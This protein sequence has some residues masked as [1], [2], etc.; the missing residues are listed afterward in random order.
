VE[1][2]PVRADDPDVV[3]L[4]D[5]LTAE[6]AGGGYTAEQTFGYSTDQLLRSAVVL[7]GARRAG[8]LV[9]I[10]GIEMQDDGAAELKRFYVEPA[11]RGQA[12]ADALLT[13]L[14]DHARERGRHRVRLE[15]GDRQA[16]A[17]RF[18]RRHG[19]RDIP[20]FGPYVGSA[21]SVCMERPV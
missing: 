18:Y 3:V 5:A 21:T 13:A 10:G 4:I 14:L 11:A 12:V 6:L 2:V 7:V 17:I 8:R 16:A 20:R 9:G 15:T 1:V 19:F